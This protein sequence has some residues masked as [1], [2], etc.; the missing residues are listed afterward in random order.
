MTQNKTSFTKGVRGRK[1]GCKN[2]ITNN[3]S[4]LK[5]LA[6][7]DCNEAYEWLKR[8]MKLGEGWAFQIFFNKLMPKVVQENTILVRNDITNPDDRILYLADKLCNFQELTREEI[9]N[10]ISLLNQLKQVNNTTGRDI[11]K[12]EVSFCNAAGEKEDAANN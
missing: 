7:E 4:E 10:E 5:K 11:Q 2:K 6:S 8:R 9:I 12:V 1:K 3:W